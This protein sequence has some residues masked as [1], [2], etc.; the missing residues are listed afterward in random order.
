MQEFD[1]DR[2]ERSRFALTMER[3][4][5]E[6]RMFVRSSG[7]LYDIAL[8]TRRQ[9]AVALVLI[10]VFGWGAFTSTM[11]F[12][13]DAMLRAKEAQVV[14]AETNY[15]ALLA[16]LGAYRERVRA[17]TDDLAKNHAYSLDL[18]ERNNGLK[19][20]LE[21]LRLQLA[22]TEEERLRIQQARAEMAG[23]IRRLRT[24]VRDAARSTETVGNG[25]VAEAALANVTE[26]RDRL[27]S[28]EAEQARAT[29]QREQLTA[30]LA[31]LDADLGDPGQADV[32]FADIASIKFELR[33]V[34]RQRDTAIQ[35]RDRLRDQ[36]V[37]LQQNIGA[38][39]SA[40]LQVYDR[41]TQVARVSIQELE[42]AIGGTGLNVDHLLRANPVTNGQGGPFLPVLEGFEDPELEE[43]IAHLG[44]HLD[45]LERLQL[46]S[47]RLP[48]AR[49]MEG[50]QITSSFGL[51]QDPITG[52]MARHEG[53][54]FGARRGTP[55]NATAAGRVVHAGRR[56]NY[57]LIV[58]IDH[59]LGFRTLYAHLDKVLVQPGQVVDAGARIGLSG[60]TGR[61]TG[62]H[63]HY[64]VLLNGT[65]V[66]PIKFLR[67]GQ[68]VFKG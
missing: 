29:A 57:G 42:G 33:R 32:Q 20:R 26:L 51:R 3:L 48:L 21:T 19:A 18:I 1:P 28:L 8:T 55:V 36:A 39:R 11:F 50:V 65:P 49:P 23:E 47:G 35:D 41:F 44:L 38:L 54:D 46:L 62:P 63:L 60:N 13:S 56:S 64:E 68:H 25:G 10:L 52:R 22:S 17:I 4:F 34:I 27:G 45:R 67:A 12:I 9:A 58:E 6:R 53:I 37:T 5:P 15:Q 7:R 24:E 43:R 40:Q 2:R 14:E 16:Q 31:E 30:E 61:S 66:N 59:G